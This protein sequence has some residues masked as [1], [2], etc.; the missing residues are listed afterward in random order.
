MATY[1]S[2]IN[3]VLTKMRENN[4]ASPG[5]SDYSLLIGSFV[6]ET[7]REVEDAWKWQALRTTLTVTT[8]QGTFQYP[9]VGAGKRFKLQDPQFS[10]FDTTNNGWILPRNASWLK[11]QLIMTTTEN[12]PSYY[13]FEGFDSNEDPLVHFYQIPNNTYVINFDLVVPQESF[14]VGTEVLSVPE[15]PVILGAYTKALAE[16]G[17]DS[18]NTHGEAMRNYQLALADAIAMDV[19]TTE[20]EA[21]W[22]V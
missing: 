7:K 1:T 9:V 19:A 12:Q 14:S 5:D 20:D 18:G 4:I 17:E 22:Y 16:R 13:Y 3:S 11:K 10:L 6:N 8:A 2:L 15:W 21:T